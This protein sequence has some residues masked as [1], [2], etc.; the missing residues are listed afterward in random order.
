MCRAVLALLA[1]LCC[2]VAAD[3]GAQ[4][5]DSK[6]R[7]T[8]KWTDE[9]GV[10]HY[11]DAIPPQF[12]QREKKVLNNQG[13]EV[14]RQAAELSP[15]EAAELAERNRQDS[16]RKQHDMF[17]LT[18]YTS[19][20]DIEQ[21]RDT[22]LDQVNGQVRA[23]EAYIENLET[24]LASLRDRSMVFAPYSD[25][26]G[27]RR[28]PD[29]LAEEIVR[30]LSELRSQRGTLERKRGEHTVMTAQFQSEINRFRELKSAVARR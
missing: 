9:R 3:V 21:V 1:L 12:A 13:V 10:I 27:A 8:Y 4:A 20:K 18:T 26:A 5:N 23:A 24:R 14:Q 2:V 17:L 25:K 6:N 7:R 28:M 15:E 16:K 19:V 11:G 22:R 29:A 30:T